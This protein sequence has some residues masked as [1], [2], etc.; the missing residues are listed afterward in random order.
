M[1]AASGLTPVLDVQDL[2]IAIPTRAGLLQAVRGIDLRI[3]RGATLGLVGESG[4]GKSLT[5]L[6]LLRLLPRGARIDAQRMTFDG[7]DLL[8]ARDRQMN[9]LRGDR[10]AMVFQ[11]PMTALNPT[12]TIGQQ[13]MT[14]YR[15]HR[16]DGAAAARARALHLLDRVGIANGPARL[17]QYPH[18]LSGGM[19]QRVLIAMALMCEP[20][21]IIADEPTTALDVTIQ[22]Q[23]LELLKTLQQEMGLAVLLITHDLGVVSHYTDD[24]SVMY[25][26]QIVESGPTAQVL[27][28][29]AHPYTQGLLGSIPQVTRRVSSERLAIIPGVVPALT[30]TPDACV[31]APRCRH[32]SDICA[33]PPPLLTVYDSQ[34]LRRCHAPFEARP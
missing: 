30:Q 12:F 24:V 3:A 17:D 23:I 1:M 5:A 27:S 22:K 26:G 18:E 20:E 11:E 32:A 15:S 31:F 29:P 2:R 14:V 25:A 33:G 9:A 10:I 7:V 28:A 21:L 6:S 13:L 4:C 19:R 8:T 34:R 16:T